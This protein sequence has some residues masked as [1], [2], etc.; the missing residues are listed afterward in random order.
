[1]AA[2][3]TEEARG[4]REELYGESI[5]AVVTHEDC[6]I[7]H[8]KT[9]ETARCWLN[10]LKLD[11]L[12]GLSFEKQQMTDQQVS[13]TVKSDH[14]GQNKSRK[15]TKKEERTAMAKATRII[16]DIMPVDSGTT[17][18]MKARSETVSS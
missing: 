11:N 12:L 18:H 5:F 8:K 4:L 3:L 16:E 14:K 9:Q 17:S 15:K 1:M 6:A 10:P 7:Y 2:R 13:T